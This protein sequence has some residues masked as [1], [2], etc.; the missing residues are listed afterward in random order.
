MLDAIRSAVRDDRYLISLHADE[1]MRQRRV[2]AWQVLT[3]V[4]EAKLLRQRPEN[5]PNP[6]V[7]L[8]QMLPDGTTVKTVWAWL[9]SDQVAKLITVHFVDR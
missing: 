1:R 2:P 8:E 3:S 4:A 7:E 9:A 5:R 6:V